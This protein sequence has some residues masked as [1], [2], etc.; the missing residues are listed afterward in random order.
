MEFI[1]KELDALETQRELTWES[2]KYSVNGENRALI[3]KKIEYLKK[4]EAKIITV[5]QLYQDSFKFKTKNNE[6]RKD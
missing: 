4:L 5:E 3:E 2:I 1:K 6:K